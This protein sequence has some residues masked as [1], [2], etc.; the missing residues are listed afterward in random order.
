MNRHMLV[1][2]LLPL[3]ACS[4]LR[5]SGGG[6]PEPVEQAAPQVAAAPHPRPPHP[7]VPPSTE[8]QKQTAVYYS[9]LGP[10]EVDV[11]TYPLMQRRNY[12]VYAAAC[13]RCHGLARSINSPLVSRT[14]WE[15]YVMSMRARGSLAGRPLSKEEVKAVLDFLEYDGQERKAKGAHDFEHLTTELKRR[16]EALLDERMSRL[17]KGPQPAL[18]N[19]P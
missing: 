12:R 6:P 15:F 17:Q 10:E 19:A 4:S 18:L 14:W 8:A 3:S 16:Y 5:W 1:V 9:D 2:L 13:S 7:V 11:S